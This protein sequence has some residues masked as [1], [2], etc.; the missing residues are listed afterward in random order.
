VIRGIDHVAL[1]TTD[2]HR[3][4]RFYTELLGFREVQRLETSH[5]GTIIFLTLGD[6]LLELFGG[7]APRRD[8]DSNPVG[9]RHL[10]LSVDDIDVE[11]ERLRALDVPFDMEPRS[12]EAGL[13]IAFFRDPDDN[14]VELMQ[15]P[16][17]AS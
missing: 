16:Q 5:S 3:A 9:L 1:V 12:V 6:T 13:R 4:A 17:A 11:Y 8:R 15:R 2:V 7:G 10:C 14:P